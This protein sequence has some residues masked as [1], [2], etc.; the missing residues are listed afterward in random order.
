MLPSIPCL[1]WRPPRCLYPPLLARLRAR[2]VFVVE[3]A[4]LFLDPP[5][6][7]CAPAPVPY[8]LL[9]PSPTQATS[10]LYAWCQSCANIPA[11][12]CYTCC[13]P[14]KKPPRFWVV[15]WLVRCLGVSLIVGWPPR[16]FAVVER[17][18][19]PSL[20]I[21]YERRRRVIIRGLSL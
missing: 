15:A 10:P 12:L 3:C 9:Q 18:C 13:P 16:T 5:L 4:S 17:R 20:W 2:A 14:P 19:F 7:W 8:P 21:V 1:W 6:F 11:V